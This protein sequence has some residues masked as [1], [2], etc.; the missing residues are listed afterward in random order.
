MRLRQLNLDLF[1]HFAGKS[2]D[3]G[4]VIAGAPDFHIIYGPNEAGKTTTMEAYLRLLYRFSAREPYDFQHQRKNLSV[5][6]ILETS[7]GDLNI[8]RLPTRVGSLVDANGTPLPETAIGAHLAGLALD[9]Y[10][11][12][13]CLD[14]DT[15][16]K[17]GDEI[18]SSKGDIGRLLFS[19]AAG[20]SDLS[21][22]LDE[23]DAQ[24]KELY[25]KS[26]T[27]TE[28]AQL[29]RA[30]AEVDGQIKAQDIP[31]PAYR[32]LRKALDNAAM[33]EAEA[34]TARAA[35]SQQLA[36][37]NV[38]QTCLPLLQKL[39]QIDADLAPIA[40]Y[41][42][43]LDTSAEDLVQM[44]T[45]QSQ[46]QAD[47]I[48]LTAEIAALQTAR[49]ALPDKPAHPDLGNRLADLDGVRSR[50][51]TGQADLQRRLDTV[52]QL[53]MQMQQTAAQFGMQD[54]PQALVLSQINLAALEQA[55]ADKR[56][57]DQKAADARA[58]IANLDERIAAAQSTRQQTQPP[59]DTV[60]G[61]ILATF[62]VDQLAPAYAAA[63]Q[64]IIAAQRQ[65]DDALAELTIKGQTFDTA[66]TCT[67][68]ASEAQELA[69][70]YDDLAR[71]IA[72]TRDT[73]DQLISD[74]AAQ[75]AQ[76]NQRLS[77][78]DLIDDVSA[79][80]IMAERDTLWQT[81]RTVL[82]AQSADRFANAMAQ[83]D[84]TMRARLAQAHDL[85]EMQQLAQTVAATRARA[86]H[87][88]TQ[89]DR[90]KS[91][92]QTVVAQVDAARASL[93]SHPLQPASFAHW[94][95]HL[96]IAQRATRNIGQVRLSYRAVLEKSDRLVAALAA[97]I[98]LDSPDFE[99]LIAHARQR[100]AA[101]R[102]LRE[103]L[104]SEQGAL[105]TLLADRAKRT[106]AYQALTDQATATHE[107]WSALVAAQF[108]GAVN[109]AQ[110]D[111]TLEPLRDMRNLDQDHAKAAHRVATIQDDIA[112]FTN[113]IMALANHAGCTP[114]PDP[115]TT[116][117]KL[118]D[119]AQQAAN[120]T[121]KQSELSQQLTAAT[122]A[123][124]QAAQ[125]LA[126]IDRKVKTLGQ[127]FG[128]QIPT[129]TLSDL[130]A[131]VQHTHNALALRSTKQDLETQICGHL[132]AADVTD[133]RNQLAQASGAYLDAQAMQINAELET[134]QASWQQAIADRAAA[135]S[136][137]RAVTGDADI[138]RL[139]ERK[140]TIELQMQ[141][142][143]LRYLSLRAGHR[144]A[145]DAIR[146]YRDTHR[147]GMMLATQTAFAELTDGAY[148]HLQTQPD[149]ANEVLIAIGAS[150]QAK[151]A[152]DMSKGTRFQLYLA[153]RAAAYEQLATQGTCLPFFC[154]DIFET[155]DETRTQAAC[156][157]L[158]RIGQR[159]QAIYL[160]HHRHVVDIARATCGDAVR[161]HDI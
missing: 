58:E 3:F 55:R 21:A 14:D 12:L 60:I 155:F 110:L 36:Q 65:L 42:S 33:V 25:K 4:A 101:A 102:D 92:Q 29:K 136:A 67:V 43:T 159:G 13:L 115:L 76:I 133:A 123:H 20:V 103:M 93:L 154:D 84:A 111:L 8:T 23:A 79:A 131:A 143:A 80:T 57:A 54:T 156:K 46:A 129:N 10:R 145:E 28:M 100:D 148:T 86:E 1:G 146:R 82:S 22:V 126:D 135:Q 97:H 61:D 56:A 53:Q 38:R 78:S 124:I 48:R 118:G 95:H 40:H 5:S 85:G 140:T 150:G 108:A 6:G 15:I 87:V 75:E 72:Q 128:T 7:T 74:V 89:L 125:T 26:A 49:D 44:L 45:S 63:Q 39:D 142:T 109:A 71:K 35:L 70:H 32:K 47:H 27:K 116:F 62:T 122:T 24:A 147:S 2:Y 88:Q 121:R 37:I 112:Q 127:S 83:V 105:D 139:S 81:H 18:A 96:A 138:A 31:A 91:D 52:S 16:E 149:G 141:E 17:G 153:L 41:P 144:L 157:M 120:A 130:R 106:A 160:T 59:D 117:K 68:T 137:L 77:G 134:A 9:D 50:F 152:H 30:W 64:A 158:A 119:L 34:S 94:V 113:A 151:R 51:S 19:A 73:R 90:L 104:A 66:P 132:N 161:V 99:T 11:N 69:A 98:A 114:A 107:T